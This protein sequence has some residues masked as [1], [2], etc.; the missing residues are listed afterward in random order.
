MQVYLDEQEKDTL[1][2]AR[3]LLEEIRLREE[4]LDELKTRQISSPK[5]DGM[6][7]GSG[8][9]DAATARMISIEGREQQIRRDRR[10]LK[11]LQGRARRAIAPLNP[12]QRIF[13][14]EYYLKGSS[15][16]TAADEARISGRTATRYLCIIGK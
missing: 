10:R 8:D 11:R 4:R 5:L 1:R 3:V 6:P 12:R 7:K 13:Y 2:A 9:G 16:E 14:T 15:A